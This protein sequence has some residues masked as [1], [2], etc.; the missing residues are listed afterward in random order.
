MRR[1]G[2]RLEPHCAHFNQLLE[3]APLVGISLPVFNEIRVQAETGCDHF[4]KLFGHLDVAS[5]VTLL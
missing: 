3:Q 1:D 5:G 2:L 4:E